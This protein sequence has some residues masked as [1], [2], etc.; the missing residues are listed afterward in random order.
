MHRDWFNE[1]FGILLLTFFG[2]LAAIFLVGGVAV[3]K[4]IVVD[5]IL[6]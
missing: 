2:T 5:G 4:H 1:L 6:K 3:I